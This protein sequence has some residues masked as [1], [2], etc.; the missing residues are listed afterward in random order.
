MDIHCYRLMH[1]NWTCSPDA[2]AHTHILSRAQKTL[3]IDACTK[4][5]QQHTGTDLNRCG[6]YLYLVI[7]D[8]QCLPDLAL[9]TLFMKSWE[10]R[11]FA[12]LAIKS[13]T[14]RGQLVHGMKWKWN[15]N[16]RSLK[17]VL[18]YLA[19][20]TRVSYEVLTNEFSV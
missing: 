11:N 15:R 3:S 17:I 20:N 19:D 7:T 18:F 14:S 10:C 8:Q 2:N 5:Q 9:D 13:C 4:K 1:S 16:Y 6:V 12:S